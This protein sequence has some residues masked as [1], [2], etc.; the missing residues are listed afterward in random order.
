VPVDQYVPVDIGRYLKKT[1]K[2]LVMAG[3]PSARS[4]GKQKKPTKEEMR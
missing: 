4:G 2:E 1:Q 3:V